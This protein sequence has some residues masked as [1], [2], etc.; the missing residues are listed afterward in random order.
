M[1]TRTGGLPIGFRKGWTD[2][3]KDVTSLARWAKDNGFEALDLGTPSAEE[4]AAVTST[5]LRLGSVDLPGMGGGMMAADEAARRE[6]IE[7][8]VAYVKNT[9]AAGAKV[10]FTCIMPGEPGRKRS[11]NYALAVESFAPVAE[12]AAQAGVVIAIEGWPG[13]GPHLPNLCCT[14]ETCRSFIKDIGL[15]S[16]R[17]NYD[18]SHLIR[19]GVDHLRFLRE[20]LPYIVHVHAKDTEIQEEAVYEFGLYQGSVFEKGHGFGEHVWRYTIPGHGCARWSEAF[21]LLSEAGFTGV[22]SVELEDEN[23]NTGEAGEKEG[24]LHSLHF[25][26]SA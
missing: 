18:P 2:W 10:F 9:A 11:E 16:V 8:N 22:V 14:P 25:L 3:Q 15:P 5:G 17:L 19:M 7:R 24:L 21:R 1:P 20:F 4:I 6:T 26:Q 23:F 12:A 13:G